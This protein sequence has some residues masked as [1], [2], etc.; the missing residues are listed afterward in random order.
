MNENIRKFATDTVN[1]LPDYFFAVAASSTGKYH[2]KYA[3]GSGGLV[4]H[5]KSAVKFAYTLLGLEQNNVFSQDEKDLMI[6]ALLLHDGWK[7]GDK[8]SSYTVTEHPV[9][10]ADW[11]MN[12]SCMETIRNHL[13]VEQLNMLC[14]AIASHMGQWT[15][16]SKSKKEVLPK[17]QTE[18]QKFVHICDYLASRKWVLVDFENDYYDGSFK[19]E[20]EIDNKIADI[21]SVCKEKVS[22][23][24]DR[25]SIYEVIQEIAGVKNPN[26]ITDINVALNVLDKIKELSA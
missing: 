3:L 15:T 24:V 22:E 1:L 11:I 9:V 4:R 17:P 23:G 6:T 19:A 5:T 20:S 10:C 25:D 2:P 7:H 13:S 18:I 8:G 26:K 21:V 12:A 14:G 16:D